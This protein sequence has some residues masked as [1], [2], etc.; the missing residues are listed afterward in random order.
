MKGD[1]QNIVCKVI[2]H[3]N[4]SSIRLYSEP[5]TNF[6]K[7]DSSKVNFNFELVLETNTPELENEPDQLL[8]EGRRFRGKEAR[9]GR[10]WRRAARGA[11]TL[12][13]N[14]VDAG[15]VYV[16]LPGARGADFRT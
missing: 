13:H 3:N 8:W 11:E 6:K 4:S 1:L 10:R 7:L 5:S 12:E 9:E 2:L 14:H 15:S 16:A